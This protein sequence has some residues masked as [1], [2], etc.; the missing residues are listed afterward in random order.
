MLRCT[1]RILPCIASRLLLLMRM[2]RHRHKQVDKMIWACFG[3]TWMTEITV[4]MRIKLNLNGPLYP[5]YARIATLQQMMATA[6]TQ[7]SLR[8]NHSFIVCS[9]SSG[10]TPWLPLPLSQ[11]PWILFHVNAVELIIMPKKVR[12]HQQVTMLLL[13]KFAN[14][15]KL[16]LLHAWFLKAWGFTYFSAKGYSTLL[17]IGNDKQG[18]RRPTEQ[19]GGKKKK[20]KPEIHSKFLCNEIWRSTGRES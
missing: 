4:Y 10:L 3:K 11:G 1:L 19:Y 12:D 18:I 17:V 7:N 15:N 8:D 2:T 5:R 9:P 13:S 6:T 14:H 16:H 20:K